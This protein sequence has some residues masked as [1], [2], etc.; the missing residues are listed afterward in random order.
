MTLCKRIIAC[1]LIENNL[2]VRRVGFKTKSI[3]GRP[4]ITIKYLQNWD[5]DEIFFINVGSKNDMSKI[6]DIASRKVFIPITVGGSISSIEEVDLLMKHGADKVVIGKYASKE[7]L[8]QI[9]DKYGDQAVCLSIDKNH[10]SIP[11]WPCGEILMHDKSRDGEGKGLNLYILKKPVYK[12]G[13]SIHKPIIAMGGVGNYDHI[14]DG[15][16]LCD[17][18]A[19]GNLFH[20]KEISAKQSKKTAFDLGYNIRL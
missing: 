5:V 10:H 12:N 8:T 6:L 14:V 15:L 1:I 17:A 3:I 20:F 7:L 9:C 11:D 4:E 16:K 19:V 2:V 13:K 18:V